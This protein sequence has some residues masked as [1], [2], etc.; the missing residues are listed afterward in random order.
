MILSEQTS[1]TPLIKV[2]P[3]KGLFYIKGR[4]MPENPAEVF[5]SLIDF[6]KAYSK[7]PKPNTLV[8]FELEFVNSTSLRY[9]TL[10]IRAFALSGNCSFTIEWNSKGVEEILPKG[11]SLKDFFEVLTQGV[12]CEKYLL[13]KTK[14]DIAIEE[15]TERFILN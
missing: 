14:P 8:R 5:G 3:D 7:N 1:S 2:I 6:T 11:Q 13:I 10:F 15:K 12:Q 9:I 4:A